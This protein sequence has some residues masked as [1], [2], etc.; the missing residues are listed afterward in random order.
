MENIKNFAR[1]HFDWKLIV[2]LLIIAFSVFLRVYHFSD[3]LIFKADQARDGNMVIRSFESGPGDLPLLGPRAAGTVL[4]LGPI[5]YYFEYLSAFVFQSVQGPVLAYPNLLFSLLTIPLFY[6]FVRKYFDRNWSMILASLFSVSFIAI[7][8]SRFAWNPNS[9][10]FFSILFLYSVLEIFDANKTRNKIWWVLAAAVSF[11]ISTQLHFSSF[12]TMP[13]I[14]LVFLLINRKNLKGVVTW[15]S[16]IIFL[17]VVV[18]LYLP[19]IF[20]DILN[21]GDNVKQFI[22][23]VGTKS[24]G[25]PLWKN[26][27]KDV[28]YFGKYFLRLL[29]GYM[30]GNR[31]WHSLMWFFNAGALLAIYKFFKKETDPNRRNFILLSILAFATQLLVY[32]PLAYTIDKPRFFLPV[33]MIPFIFLGFLGKYFFEEK[34][35]IYGKLAVVV[36]VLV[37]FLGNVFGTSAWLWEIRNSQLNAVR[38]QDTIILKAKRDPAWLVWWHF[39]K[40]AAY[41]SADCEKSEIYFALDKNIREY[42]NSLQYTLENSGEKRKLHV[43]AHDFKYNSDG[44]YYYVLQADKPVPQALVDSLNQDS[45]ISLGEMGIV[46]LSFKEN[47]VEAAKIQ[48]TKKEAEAAKKATEAAKVSENPPETAE[49][50]IEVTKPADNSKPEVSAGPRLERAYWKDVFEY[51]K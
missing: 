43:V 10:P 27:Y 38:A 45:R 1:K 47:A 25:R 18:L 23:S 24:S 19:V 42:D 40:A 39:E 11:S 5:F 21:K 30:G 2:F 32:V 35:I 50:A 8:Y 3:W 49:S 13:L 6:F 31:I 46:R 37:S 12:I 26:I 48:M 4:R 41:I 44:C 9:L 36:I 33:I 20:S 15:K 29:T 28:Y 17:A 34:K 14:I 7:E 22:H 16:V 51:Y